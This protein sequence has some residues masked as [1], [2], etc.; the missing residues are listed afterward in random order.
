M[1]V[2]KSMLDWEGLDISWFV[3]DENDCIAVM[4][5]CGNHPLPKSVNLLG[6]DWDV[7]WDYFHQLQP[8]INNTVVINDNLSKYIKFAS[9]KTRKNVINAYSEMVLKGLYNYEGEAR[10]IEESDGLYFCTGAPSSP[11]KI[12]ELP[13]VIQSI[14][15][16]TSF[17]KGSFGFETLIYDE[18]ID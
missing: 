6:D 16:K 8:K 5:T 17:K 15:K 13:S 12:N 1:I 7:L 3:V 9:R 4:N 2:E 18:D 11:L 10:N 14:L